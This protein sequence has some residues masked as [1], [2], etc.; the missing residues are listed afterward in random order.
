MDNRLTRQIDVIKTYV[1]ETGQPTGTVSGDMVLGALKVIQ[2]LFE[3]GWP[4]CSEEVSV[5][6]EL[7][8]LYTVYEMLDKIEHP[9]CR[10]ADDHEVMTREALHRCRNLAGNITELLPAVDPIH[11]ALQK[12]T[13]DDQSEHSADQAR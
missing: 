5:S 7:H 1:E 4:T 11:F 12:E 13:I 2:A 9:V 10:W 8:K 3:D 6:I